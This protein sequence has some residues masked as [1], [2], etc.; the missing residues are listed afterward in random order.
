MEH[1]FNTFCTILDQP[2]PNTQPLRDLCAQHALQ[3]E[4][5][6]FCCWYA[7]HRKGMLSPQSLI[8]QLYLSRAWQQ[9]LASAT[10]LSATLSLHSKHLNRSLIEPFVARIN[11]A[12][13][14]ALIQ[15]CWQT[16]QRKKSTQHHIRNA[17]QNIWVY[18]RCARVTVAHQDLTHIITLIHA[19]WPSSP[20]EF[21]ET[22]VLKSWERS[23]ISYLNQLRLD[24]I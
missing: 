8:K 17:C 18:C 16:H 14:S 6:M 12:F 7:Q 1:D 10:R 15:G 21:V 19:C 22:T 2:S 20:F 5:L 23:N 13:R 9:C 24:L 3:P 11:T 4:V